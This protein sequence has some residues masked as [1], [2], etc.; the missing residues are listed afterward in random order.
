M[1]SIP[2]GLSL[3]EAAD[4][5][6]D[7]VVVGAGPAGAMAARESA[8]RGYQVLLVDKTD[9]PR[10]KICGCCLNGAAVAVLDATGLG[11]LPES[12]NA[13]RLSEVELAAGGVRSRLDLPGG[14]SL[15]RERLDYALIREAMKAG[16]R[17]LPSTKCSWQAGGPEGTELELGGRADA[18]AVRTR[19]VLAADGL[20]AGFTR[21]IPGIVCRQRRGA[22]LGA[23]VTF[24]MAD[25]AVR[26]NAIHMTVGRGGYVGMVRLED[27]R[28]N[29]AAAFDPQ[30]VKEAGGLAAAA[31]GILNQ[32]GVKLRFPEGDQRWQGTPPL[33]R[34]YSPPRDARVLLI[35]DAAG[36]VEPFTGEGMA[37][38]LASGAAVVPILQR[39]LTDPHF[40]GQDAWQRRYRVVL[41]RRQWSCRLLAA[42]L[43]R[44]RLI[45]LGLRVLDR[46]PALAR[47]YLR[48]LNRQATLPA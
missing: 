24:E 6:W 1:N 17:F 8:R 14:Y 3:R 45:G 2:A 10:W 34:I 25:P 4:V 22:R 16:C 9:F 26:R 23:G 37:W 42:L 41:G 46:M 27:G 18:V 33:T 36:Y 29:V 19:W 20:A 11:H 30:W 12:L 15:S 28:L 32:A 47:P 21:H 44:P 38:A 43:R 31:Q 7:V 48:R 5:L 35:G 39:A 13:V 40:D